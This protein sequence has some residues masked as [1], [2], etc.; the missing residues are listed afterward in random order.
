MN[1]T[2]LIPVKLES[3]DRVRNLKTVLTYLLTKFDAKIQVQEHDVENKFTKLVMPY[4]NERFGPII[5]R[6]EYTSISRQ[7]HIFT[8][9][10][11]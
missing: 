9:L 6:L 11:Y 3:E 10:K 4:I 5:H 2:F 7:N 1:L 8:R